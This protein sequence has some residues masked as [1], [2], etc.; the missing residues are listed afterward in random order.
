MQG[1]HLE[2]GPF[3]DAPA[4]SLGDVVMEMSGP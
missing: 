3:G 1:F 2:S 4:D